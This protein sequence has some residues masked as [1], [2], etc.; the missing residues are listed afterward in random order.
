MSQNGEQAARGAPNLAI[1]AMPKRLAYVRRRTTANILVDAI[2]SMDHL[3][4]HI[5]VPTRAQKPPTHAL[6]HEFQ[7]GKETEVDITSS[8]ASRLRPDGLP[9][10]GT[11]I[12]MQ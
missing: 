6:K 2:G 8:A 7:D 10:S 11:C 12:S 5:L 1:A 9:S 4:T 3:G